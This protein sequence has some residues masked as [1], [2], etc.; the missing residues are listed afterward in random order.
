M[1][2]E[3]ELLDIDEKFSI[4]GGEEITLLAHEEIPD[5]R[6][7]PHHARLIPFIDSF[8]DARISELIDIGCGPGKSVWMLQDLLGAGTYVGID[9]SKKAIDIARQTFPDE[10]FHVVNLYQ[11]PKYFSGRKFRFFFAQGVLNYVSPSK[12]QDALAA[13]HAVIEPGGYGMITLPIGSE[14]SRIDSYGEKEIAHAFTSHAWDETA[15]RTALDHAGFDVVDP[16]TCYDCGILTD[17]VR[18]KM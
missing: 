4:L 7:G 1:R 9:A 11:L 3:F 8:T 5:Q 2:K 18:K 16:V 6:A 14:S 17:I 10:E 15:F 13:I 12:M